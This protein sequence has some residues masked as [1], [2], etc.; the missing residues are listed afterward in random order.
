M[1]LRNYLVRHVLSVKQVEF[2]LI[3]LKRVI[4]ANVVPK[5]ILRREN[6]KKKD[7]LSV[8]V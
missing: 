5:V 7:L 6:V 4:K 1:F 2:V 8:Q 3:L